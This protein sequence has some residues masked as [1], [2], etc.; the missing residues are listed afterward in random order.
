MAGLSGL[1]TLCS[2]VLTKNMNQ[3]VSNNLSRGEKI[4]A[5]NKPNIHTKEVKMPGI[6]TKKIQASE[7]DLKKVD[8]M[9]KDAVAAIQAERKR[10]LEERRSS[11]PK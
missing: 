9:K 10:R 8:A 1:W 5:E 11:L 6:L 7:A 3:T 2:T 4:I